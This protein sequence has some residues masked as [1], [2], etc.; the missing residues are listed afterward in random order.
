VMRSSLEAL[1]LGT[2][3]KSPLILNHQTVAVLVP[4]YPEPGRVE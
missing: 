1:L 3:K 4:S 2:T